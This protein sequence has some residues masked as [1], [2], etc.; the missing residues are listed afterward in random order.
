LSVD[1]KCYSE[2][3]FSSICLTVPLFFSLQ[4]PYVNFFPWCNRSYWTRTSSLSR[5]DDHTQKHNT[6]Y[7]SSGRVISPTQDFYLTTRNTHKRQISMPPVGFEP[8]IP[9]SKRPQSQTLK[10]Y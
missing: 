6:R 2:G 5:T 9:A 7:N 4:D 3:H 8:T 1:F 10:I